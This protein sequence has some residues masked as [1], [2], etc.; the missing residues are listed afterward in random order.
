MANMTAI[1]NI[2]GV[3]GTKT[4]TPSHDFLAAL[5][6]AK[7]RGFKTE[8]E[9][10]KPEQTGQPDAESE[11]ETVQPNV[12]DQPLTTATD[13]AEVEP[14]TSE[15]AGDDTAGKKPEASSQNEADDDI[16]LK[17]RKT[18]KGR[19]KAF[20][21]DMTGQ[22]DDKDATDPVETPDTEAPEIEKVDIPVCTDNGKGNPLAGLRVIMEQK[23]QASAKPLEE[24]AS[25]TA[26]DVTLTVV[27]TPAPALGAELEQTKTEEESLPSADETLQAV[28]AVILQVEAKLAEADVILAKANADADAAKAAQDKA[29]ADFK[30]AIM[31]L[32]KMDDV[33][34]KLADERRKLDADAAELAEAQAKFNETVKAAADKASAADRKER[35]LR[36]LERSPRSAAPVQQTFVVATRKP[37]PI[38][39]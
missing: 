13:E 24:P 3:L 31:L 4:P 26:G 28:E 21:G 8:E 33:A 1:K 18:V 23:A 25:N 22:A 37:L 30:V 38:K 20:Q 12:T 16:P 6:I 19:R 14:K 11:Q 27:V 39:F 32:L 7:A 35:R 5:A 29:D 10:H 34:K 17:E 15:P 9:P 2:A 36:I